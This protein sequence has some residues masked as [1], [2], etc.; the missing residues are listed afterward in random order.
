MMQNFGRCIP[1]KPVFVE[2]PLHSLPVYSINYDFVP[3]AAPNTYPILWVDVKFPAVDL[4]LRLGM[5]IFIES[6]TKDFV[7]PPQFL[8]VQDIIS[9][10]VAL[11]PIVGGLPTQPVYPFKA[12]DDFP[13]NVWSPLNHGGRWGYAT[14]D[15]A[16]LPGTNQNWTYGNG[17]PVAYLRY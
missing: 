14:R 7:P 9:T 5:Q 4:G 13:K 6:L 16:S 1:N 12:K 15:L 8:K 3:G 2:R 10:R 11:S 17:D